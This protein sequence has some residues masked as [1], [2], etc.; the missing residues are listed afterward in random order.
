MCGV[1]I[2][3]TVTIDDNGNM[4]TT[5]GVS[6]RPGGYIRIGAREIKNETDKT[7][8]VDPARLEELQSPESKSAVDE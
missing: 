3:D 5:S 4:Q 1:N 8:Q 2:G 6:V 7:I